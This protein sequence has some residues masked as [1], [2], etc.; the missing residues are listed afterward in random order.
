[1]LVDEFVSDKLVDGITFR[2]LTVIDQFTRECVW[3]EADHSTTGAKVVAATTKV[4]AERSGPQMCILGG[5]ESEFANRIIEAWA[6]NNEVWLCFIRPGDRS[7]MFSRRVLRAS[8]YTL[9]V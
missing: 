5:N 7:R 4:A 8:A 6:I 3:L 9:T 2:I 1:M